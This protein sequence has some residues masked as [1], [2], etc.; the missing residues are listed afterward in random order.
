MVNHKLYENGRFADELKLAKISPHFKKN[1]YLDKENY[2]PVN[3]LSH[4]WKV[5]GI[6]MHMKIDIFMRDKL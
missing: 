2:K 6:I 5:F 1:D 4:V 3:I